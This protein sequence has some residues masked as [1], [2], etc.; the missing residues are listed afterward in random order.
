[1][2]YHIKRIPPSP[3]TRARKNAAN[4]RYEAI[5]QRPDLKSDVPVVPAEVAADDADKSRAKNSNG[6]NKKENRWRDPMLPILRRLSKEGRKW[7]TE[8]QKKWGKVRVWTDTRQVQATS[9]E[10]SDIWGRK[11]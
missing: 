10:K 5:G 11:E 2:E 6:T 4:A 1:M 3:L 9:P 7:N 8:M